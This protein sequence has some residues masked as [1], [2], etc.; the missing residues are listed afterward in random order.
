MNKRYVCFILFLI[1]AVAVL[2]ANDAEE[3]SEIVQV[4]GVVRLVG[5][6]LFSEIVISTSDRRNW[7]VTRE[8]RDK[9]HDL[10]QQ[11]VTVEGEEVIVEMRLANG[12]RTL[13][14]RELHNIRIISQQE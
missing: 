13:T 14:R 6:S 3:K 2:S 8:D 9:L 1:F 12:R 5:S 4:T 11:I 10:Q 7:Y